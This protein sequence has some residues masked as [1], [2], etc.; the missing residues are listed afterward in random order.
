MTIH[1]YLR[2]KVLDTGTGSIQVRNPEVN[3]GRT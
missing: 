3:G 2:L 1:L